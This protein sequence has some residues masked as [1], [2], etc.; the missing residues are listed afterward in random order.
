MGSGELRV[1]FEFKGCSEKF[2]LVYFFIFWESRDGFRFEGLRRGFFVNRVMASGSRGMR[3]GYFV[4]HM[5]STI[6]KLGLQQ[7]TMP[8]N[9]RLALDLAGLIVYWEQYR[10]SPPTPSQVRDTPPSLL[11]HAPLGRSYHARCSI[12][13][14]SHLPVREPLFFCLF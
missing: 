6:L 8:E 14:R 5:L 13:A 11:L 7:Q 9:R 2:F 3:R 1:D 12:A 10:Q 4:N